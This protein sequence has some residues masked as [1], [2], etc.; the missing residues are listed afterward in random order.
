MEKAQ[1]QPNELKGID[2][3]PKF[4]FPLYPS[5]VSEDDED[6]EGEI[7]EEYF[8]RICNGKIKGNGIARGE[9]EL[10]H[11][12]RV[13]KCHYVHHFEPYLNLGPFN[14][15]VMMYWPFRTV[16][17]DFFTDYEM[18]YIKNYTRPK[19][20]STRIVPDSTKATTKKGREMRQR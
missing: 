11:P 8:R 13:K 9:A 7:E 20:S 4:R 3:E 16:I 1:N 5:Q 12:N 15:E 19:L 10:G 6:F 18:D 14:L 2:L 17:H